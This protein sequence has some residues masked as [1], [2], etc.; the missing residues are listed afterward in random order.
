MQNNLLR[1]IFQKQLIQNSLSYGKQFIT[2]SFQKTAYSKQLMA[3][4]LQKKKTY[5]K[6]LF[7]QNNLLRFLFQKQL[8]Q[9][10]LFIQNN[11]W[12]L[13]SKNNLFIQNN[14][15]R[16]L[17]KKTAYSKQLIYVK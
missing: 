7:I 9:N 5:S 13:F 15:L 8:I 2:I 17:F 11:L 12:R 16:S 6:N 4:Y 3:T 10:N 1:P 14:L